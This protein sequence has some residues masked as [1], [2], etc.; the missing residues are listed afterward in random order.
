MNFSIQERDFLQRKL[1][2]LKCLRSREYARA[3][4]ILGGLI[5]QCPN[6][7]A[8]MVDNGVAILG[9][10]RVDEAIELFSRCLSTDPENL[11][12]KFHL[13][14]ALLKSG[15]ALDA[16]DLLDSLSKTVPA[17]PEVFFELG[18]AQTQLGQVYQAIQ[19][20]ETS[21]A[22]GANSVALFFNLGNLYFRS[23]SYDTALVNYLRC[24]EL[25]EDFHDVH[26]ALGSL[27]LHVGKP[28]QAIPHLKLA[29]N[30]NPTSASICHNLALAYQKIQN[31][32]RALQWFQKSLKISPGKRTT[33]SQL[34]NLRTVICDPSVYNDPE[35]YQ[36]RIFGGVAPFTFLVLEDSPERQL[37]RS[38]DFVR[39]HFLGAD[40]GFRHQAKRFSNKKISL[41][42]YSA[43]FKNHATMFLFGEILRKLDR[44][45]FSVSIF[46]FS[47]IQDDVTESVK[48][49]A[50]HFFDIFNKSDEEAV[51]ISRDQGLDIAL[52][53]KG[54]TENAR[55]GLFAMRV[56]PIQINYLGYPGSLGAPWM[57]Y[58]I[59]DRFVVPES[60]MRFYDE[61]V[62]YLPDCYQPNTLKRLVSSCLTRAQ[63]NL[64]PS[65]FVF[66]SFN[67]SYKIT[68]IEIEV[69]SKVLALAPHSVLWLFSSNKWA[70]LNIKKAF[71][72]AGIAKERIVFERQTDQE[73][74]LA[75]YQFADLFLDTFNVG[76][77]TT[78][79]DALFMDTPVITRPGRQFASRVAGSILRTMD[80][81]ELITETTE[82][83]INLAVALAEKPS[84]L[85]RLVG[86]IK[87][88]KRTSH[89]F[90]AER[91]ARN[92]EGLLESVLNQSPHQGSSRWDQDH[93]KAAHIHA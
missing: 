87:E 69:W 25:D 21:R 89:F 77:H 67:Q 22:L 35:I 36:E 46:S 48:Q 20:F 4:E 57:D 53:L 42:L 63:T 51:A 76:A 55:P 16:C 81:P 38:Q 73:T 58:L 12:A 84:D 9:L 61:K 30:K 44:S 49:H 88:K 74:H 19:S 79:G 78:A 8:L 91:Y 27:F 5:K 50:D 66:C 31:Y 64:P 65:G 41:G 75:R 92:F 43:D 80:L 28:G 24:I 71:A 59:A 6:D 39:T 11:S 90:N 54:Y 3:A 83:Y 2:G 60:S 10:G 23:A 40:K 62:L 82:E 17:R 34:Q 47:S 7:V 18:Q 93:V 85:R 70:E 15:K 52:D 1:R 13:G 32:G 56:A 26:Q 86:R 72:S 45:K 14:R 33:W 68:P 29:L 37:L